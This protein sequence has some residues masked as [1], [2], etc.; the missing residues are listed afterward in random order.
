MVIDTLNINNLLDSHHYLGFK[1]QF[2][3]T[4]LEFNLN[5]LAMFASQ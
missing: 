2:F 1:C 3:L 5:I 4:F